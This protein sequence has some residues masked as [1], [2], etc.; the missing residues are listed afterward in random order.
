MRGRSTRG[1]SRSLLVPLAL[2]M[3]GAAAFAD[4][5][6]L[7]TDKVQQG[8]GTIDLLKNMTATQLQ[9]YLTQNGMLKLGVDVNENASGNETAKSEGVALKNVSLTITTTAGTFT[10][11]NFVTGDTAM[12]QEAGTTTEQQFYTVFGQ[13]GSS[14]LTSS[15][16]SF[17]LAAYDDVILLQNVSFQGQILSASLNVQ[18]LSTSTLKGDNNESFFDFSGGFEDMALLSSTDARMLETAKI[19][20]ADAPPSIVYTTAPPTVMTTLLAEPTPVAAPAPVPTT[21]TTAP[22]P[23]AL[24]PE[25]APGPSTSTADLPPMSYPPAAPAAS[26]LLMASLGFLLFFKSRQ[27]A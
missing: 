15:T 21:T 2:A 10:F 3:L 20:I 9:D 16:S 22:A 5:S 17:N 23:A 25:P 13:A 1:V 12:I 8:S 11:S 4:F 14:Q 18:L 7:L 6:T 27:R 19:G 24:F 26:L